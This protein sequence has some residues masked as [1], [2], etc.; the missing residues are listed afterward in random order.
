MAAT[1]IVVP[2]SEA[3]TATE[4][5]RRRYTQD[6]ADGMPPHVTLL[7]PFVD[8]GLLVAGQVRTLRNTLGEFQP[9]EFV[10]GAFAEFPASAT[11]A[12]VLYLAPEP[13]DP[14]REMTHAISAAF[15]DYPPYG[16]EFATVVPHLTVAEDDDAPLAEIRANVTKSLPITA[17]AAEAHVMRLGA[18]GWRTRGRILLGRSGSD[19]RGE[20]LYL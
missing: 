9:F 15:P 17:R 4:L 20:P 18:D 10:L 6:G 8:D 11:T 2:V 3:E 12:R 16:G 5:W 19:D 13:S 7:Y 1:A 14:F